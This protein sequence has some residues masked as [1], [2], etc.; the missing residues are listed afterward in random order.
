MSEQV[1]RCSGH[2][3][4]CGEFCW[5]QG[6]LWTKP[7]NLEIYGP[8]AGKVHVAEEYPD[9]QIHYCDAHGLPEEFWEQKKEQERVLVIEA[10]LGKV[11]T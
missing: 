4:L 8:C 1:P 2:G 5:V 3:G 7:A 10:T 6:E 11:T 9:E